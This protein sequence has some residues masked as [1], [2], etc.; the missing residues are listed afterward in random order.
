MA[1]FYAPTLFCTLEHNDNIS[2]Y[3]VVF[4]EALKEGTRDYS[5][6]KEK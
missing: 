4:V 5:V 6:L 3:Y 2:D 1:A